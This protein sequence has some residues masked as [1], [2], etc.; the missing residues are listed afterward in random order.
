[1][2]DPNM[3][4][5]KPEEEELFK[6]K[7][8]LLLLESDLAG[9]ELCL[10]AWRSELATFERLY[11]KTLG[12]RYAQ[13]DEIEATI[14]EQQA[15][16]HPNRATHHSA[17]EARE[18]AAKSRALAEEL[19]SGADHTPQS[20]TLKSLYR[21][22]AK[23]IHPDL[24][25]DPMDRARREQLMADANRAY[26]AGD[27]EGLRAILHEYEAS[28]ESFK[29]E[30]TAA[31]LVRAIRKI[32]QI[33]QRVAQIKRE[34]EVLKKSDLYE[35]KVKV[36]RAATAGRDLLREMA[37]DL[38]AEIALSQKRLDHLSAKV[39]SP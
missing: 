12:S 14:A 31:E 6:R 37:E 4:L 34:I 2:S 35:L 17:V 11:L 32:A 26:E 16:L 19:G 24:V 29:G 33:K 22:V 20:R 5:T 10:T 3:R 7:A 39:S 27:E 23:R 36:D 38:D 21:E 18:R 8:E 1:M 28:P 9:Q 15:R 30:G 25:T 13:L